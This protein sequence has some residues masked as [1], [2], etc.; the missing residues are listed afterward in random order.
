MGQAGWEAAWVRD[1]GHEVTCHTQ[2]LSRG[3]DRGTDALWEWRNGR[4]EGR[5]ADL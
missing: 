5:A 4:Q 2:R 1:G 3:C